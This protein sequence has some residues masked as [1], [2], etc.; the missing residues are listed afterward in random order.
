MKEMK[1]VSDVLKTLWEIYGKPQNSR[2]IKRYGDWAV[3]TD[4]A[5][6][7]RAVENWVSSESRF[8]ALSDLIRVYK[9]EDRS[10][11]YSKSI[12]NTV[13]C[14]YCGETGFVPTIETRND[15]H[16]IVQMKCKCTNATTSGIQEYFYVFKEVEYEEYANE[17]RDEMSYPQIVDKYLKEEI[18]GVRPGNSYSLE[19]VDVGF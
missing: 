9:I 8:P 4:Y 7:A 5:T 1:D 13:D 15:R 12:L 3:T 6:L 10:N 2:Q 11:N 17:Y 16:Y 19:R 18:L 14:W